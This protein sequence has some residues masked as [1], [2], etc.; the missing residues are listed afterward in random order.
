[1]PGRA[2]A[3]GARVATPSI[4]ARTLH[5]PVP[6]ERAVPAQAVT[7]TTPSGYPAGG[8]ATPYGYYAPG[9]DPYYYA[10]APYYG[11][12]YYN[13]W[14][15]GLMFTFTP[16]YGYASPNPGGYDD[17][18]GGPGNT[19]GITGL[20]ENG[21]A[22]YAHD[23]IKGLVTVHPKNISVEATDSGKN[24][25]YKFKVKDEELAIVTLFNEDNK[26]LDLVKLSIS[27]KKLW[28]VIHTGTLNLYDDHADFIYSPSDIAINH[29][30]V[31]YNGSTYS[32][33]SANSNEAK[34][35]LTEFV[36]RAYGKNLR[37]RAFSWNELLV[38]IDKLD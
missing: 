22:V 24:Y 21:Y 2:A 36:N 37:A 16:N 7:R 8:V 18:N 1:M 38:Y 17:N 15:A 27:Q 12:P 10:F 30:V 3:G 5:L 20:P 29:L 28:R 9:Y 23:T 32:L 6:H 19:P 13:M 34:E 31:N 26:E 25:D 4:P 35:R 33:V 14:S 11:Y